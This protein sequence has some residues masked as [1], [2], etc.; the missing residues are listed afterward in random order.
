MGD[1]AFLHVEDGRAD[2]S[3]LLDAIDASYLAFRRRL[4]SIEQA[5]SCD[6]NACSQAP[7]LDLKYFVHHGQYV[8]SRIAGRDELAGTSVIV[9][10]RLLKGAAAAAAHAE[11]G[12]ASGF[13]VFTGDAAAALGL[14]VVAGGLLPAQESIEHVGEVQTYT[15]DLEARWQIETS[16]RR[17]EGGS[18]QMIL[19]VGVD[20]VADA[21]TAWRSITSPALRPHWDGPIVIL[22][23]GDG[24]RGVGT[25]A[26]CVTGVLATLEEIVDWQPYEHVGYRTT[27]PDLGPVAV[28]YDLSQLDGGGTSI[29]L[30]WDALGSGTP[31][32]TTISRLA[33]ERTD[34]LRRLAAFLA[35]PAATLEEATA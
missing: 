6:C 21:A 8:Q 30:R 19:D 34:A 12:R 16:A 3:L 1:A 2:P 28:T 35:S 32:A 25:R 9:V 26:Q 14:D 22:E 4:R 7:R 33:A 15:D 17:L 20:V 27:A 29:R 5:T 10:H 24:R 23:A 13:A 11:D 31:P 18:G